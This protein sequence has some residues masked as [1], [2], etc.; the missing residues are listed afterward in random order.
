MAPSASASGGDPFPHQVIFMRCPRC[1]EERSSVIDSRAD[2]G[3]IRRRRECQSCEYRFT[4]YERVELSLPVV[5]KKDGRREA[6]DRNKVRT[7]IARACEKRPVSAQ[8]VDSLVDQIEYRVSEMCVREV[9]SREIGEHIISALREVDEIAYV[10]FASVYREFS[11]VGQF[12]DTLLALGAMGA[13]QKQ[14]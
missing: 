12:V 14:K 9:S 1:N 3:A 8:T 5:V 13:L 2:G 4:T 10:R 6:F 7:G 11:E